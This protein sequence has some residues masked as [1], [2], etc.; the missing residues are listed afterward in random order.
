MASTIEDI[1]QAVRLYT[2]DYPELN[3]L[4]DGE[5]SSDRMIAFSIVLA[6]DEFS[7]TP[8][9]IASYDISNFPSL[10]LLIRMTVWHLLQ[11]VILLSMRNYLPYSDGGGT[12]G[13][14]EGNVQLLIGWANMMGAMLQQQ[15]RQLK[16]AL[17]INNALGAPGLRSE[18][19]W[20]HGY[21]S[22]LTV[23][24]PVTL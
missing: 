14:A 3:R 20:V 16:V 24:V 23:P 6:L 22:R 10:S 8:P 9:L 2:R 12:P 21:L 18:Y 17:N 4:I 7:N 1:V 11:Q 13:I 15:E 19:S 5:E